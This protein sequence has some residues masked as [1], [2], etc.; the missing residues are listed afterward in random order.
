M[1]CCF[2]VN[3]TGY[4]VFFAGSSAVHQDASFWRLLELGKE[5]DDVGVVVHLQIGAQVALA[6]VFAADL[7]PQRSGKFDRI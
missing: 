7:V 2:D 5:C 3:C 6:A 4:M 1:L